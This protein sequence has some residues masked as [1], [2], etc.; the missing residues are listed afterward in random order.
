MS[1]GTQV[2]CLQGSISPSGTPGGGGG[3]TYPAVIVRSPG[4]GHR[5]AGASAYIDP[6]VGSVPGGGAGGVLSAWQARLHED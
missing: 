2:S 4:Y 1:S 6:G 3:S 5:A